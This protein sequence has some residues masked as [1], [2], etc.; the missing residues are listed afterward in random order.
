[1][2]GVHITAAQRV[3]MPFLVVMLVNLVHISYF[4]SANKFAR[5][6]PVHFMVLFRKAAVYG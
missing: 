1:M 2:N 3:H 5:T 6:E 4:Y